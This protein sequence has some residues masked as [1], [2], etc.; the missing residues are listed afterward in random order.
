[1]EKR[2]TNRTE[3]KRFMEV[4]LSY[5]FEVVG[6]ADRAFQRDRS[7]TSDTMVKIGNMGNPKAEAIIEK[8]H[9]CR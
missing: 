6:S 1:M 8:S 7:R 2:R 4:S 9:E 5:R 3:N